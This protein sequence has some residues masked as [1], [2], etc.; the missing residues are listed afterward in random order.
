MDKT[1]W[2]INK[3]L[4]VRCYLGL[5][6]LSA[7]QRDLYK[8]LT[9][10]NEEFLNKHRGECCFILGS[11]P[12]LKDQDISLLKDQYV[13][14]V[15]DLIR[16]EKFPE[17]HTNYH[18]FADQVYFDSQY[19]KALGTHSLLKTL[20]DGSEDGPICFV[21]C[22]S[23]E[24]IKNLPDVSSD[25]I[26]YFFSPLHFYDNYKK[27]FEL[28]KKVPAF[29]NVVQYAIMIA[30]YMGF[31]EIYLLGCDSTAMIEAVNIALDSYKSEHVFHISDS[32]LK[33]MEELHKSYDMEELFTG[34]SRVFHSYKELHQ[35]CCSKNV[36]LVN[37]SSKSILNVIPRKKFE[38][39]LL[40]KHLYGGK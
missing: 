39:V 34:W 3:I 24:Y 38:D 4:T 21:P 32:E 31:S 7:S 18:I 14:T 20:L 40:E 30:L 28:T 11:G 5:R 9:K 22:A 13:F 25:H 26:R 27:D 1:N 33:N 35:Y 12:S 36:S 23:Y 29:R 15:N 6:T 10:G 17:C 2:L 19:S 37:C 8:K 16:Y